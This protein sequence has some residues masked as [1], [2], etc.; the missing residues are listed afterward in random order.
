MCKILALWEILISI[1]HGLYAQEICNIK[2][3]IN[4]YA[5]IAAQQEI[6]TISM[7]QNAIGINWKSRSLFPL[8]HK[9]RILN[10]E[11]KYNK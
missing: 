10:K 7:E 9:H 2:A 4:M 1:L 11:I 3:G 8:I 6:S 5:I